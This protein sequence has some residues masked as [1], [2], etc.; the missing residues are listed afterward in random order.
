[1]L[2][3]GSI[4][5]ACRFWEIFQGRGFTKCA[6]VTSYNPTI[7]KAKGETTGEDAPTDN[8]KKFEVYEKMLGKQSVEDFEKA[9]KKRFIQQPGQMK[10]VHQGRKWT[11]EGPGQERARVAYATLEHGRLAYE[12]V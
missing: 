8:L 7:D 3:A 12:L 2:V 10:L 5:E 9:A 11:I 4:Y 6:V 1:M